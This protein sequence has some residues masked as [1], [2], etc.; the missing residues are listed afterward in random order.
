MYVC[1]D[2]FISGIKPI[3]QHTQTH[4][5]NRRELLERTELLMTT[6]RNRT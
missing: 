1:I 6:S 4:S 2:V 5:P 3:E